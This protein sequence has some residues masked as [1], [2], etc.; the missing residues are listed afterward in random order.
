MFNVP[1]LSGDAVLRYETLTQRE[2]GA[3]R[4]I[5]RIPRCPRVED[6]TIAESSGGTSGEEEQQLRT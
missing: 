1:P 6:E 4:D 3:Y 2:W 5:R